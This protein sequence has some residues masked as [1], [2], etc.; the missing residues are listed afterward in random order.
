MT[1]KSFWAAIA[2]S[3]IILSCGHTDLDMSVVLKNETDNEI[4]I[5]SELFV[6]ETEIYIQQNSNMTVKTYDHETMYFIFGDTN[7]RY[8]ANTG[9]IEKIRYRYN[10]IFKR[11]NGELVC[12]VSSNSML[13]PFDRKAF[14]ITRIDEP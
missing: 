13:V 5:S 2:A 14:D 10:L 11:E 4:Y 9:Y 3:F 1:I 12:Y 6:Q 7:V 8:S